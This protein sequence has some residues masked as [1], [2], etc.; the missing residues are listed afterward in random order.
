MSKKR[1]KLKGEM[2]N[3]VLATENFLQLLVHLK[4]QSTVDLKAFILNVEVK[5]E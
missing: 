2:S 1:N 5:N 3:K 4:A